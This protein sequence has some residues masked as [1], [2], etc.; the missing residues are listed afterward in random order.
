MVVPE[1][2]FA[3]EKLRERND[4]QRLLRANINALGQDLFVLAEEFGDWSGSSRRIDLLCLDRDARLVVVELKR[5]EDGGHMELQAIRYAAMVSTMTLERAIQTY[6]NTLPSDD[7]LGRAT[8]EIL[9]FLN[10]SR[11]DEKEL[12][13]DVRIVLVAGDFS[14]EL[15][16]SVLWLNKRGLDIACIRLK[17]YRLGEAVIIDVAQLIP[18][19]ETEDYL[20]RLRDQEQ[21]QRRVAT[22]RFDVIRQ[23]WSR[24]IELSKTMTNLLANR[25][26]TQDNWLTSGLGRSGFMLISRVQSNSASVECYIRLQEREQTERAF[27]TLQS[28]KAQIEET[29]GG[30]LVWEELVGDVAT[31]IKIDFDQGYGMPTEK[32][33][34]LQSP[35]V[36][37]LVRL[38][39]ALRGPIERLQR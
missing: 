12:S 1:T 38:D 29:F 39:R 2:T 10:I 25:K 34:D 30:S 13:G 18:L 32:W 3:N 4:L 36:D 5:T 27:K 17:P 22:G 16:T 31:R 35:M 8:T 7:A 15:S 19:P 11:I 21:E 23:F 20:I 26:T 6:A 37:S 33:Q 28:E 24:Y 9:T 14:Q